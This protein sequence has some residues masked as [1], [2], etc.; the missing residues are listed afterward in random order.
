TGEG[1]DCGLAALNSDAVSRDPCSMKSGKPLALLL[2]LALATS[3]CLATP[4]SAQSV[5]AKTNQII[6]L[7]K[8]GK[9]A[10]ALPL[11]QKTLADAEK[12]GGPAHR[13]VAAALNNLGQVYS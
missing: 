7:I 4:A 11:A 1:L 12:A 10:E 2:G 3:A 6:E 13:D 5:S 9:Y 8:V